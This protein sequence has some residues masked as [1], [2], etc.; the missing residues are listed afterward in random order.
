M[1]RQEITGD[2]RDFDTSVPL[3]YLAFDRDP[4]RLES[5]SVLA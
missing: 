3:S 2:K 4:I 5:K 1:E